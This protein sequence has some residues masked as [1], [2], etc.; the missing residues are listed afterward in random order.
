M[1]TLP[2]SIS[3]VRRTGFEGETIVIELTDGMSRTRMLEVQMQMLD[4]A[5][6]V[7]GVGEMPCEFRLGNTELAGW[8]RDVKH[9]QVTIEYGTF[10]PTSAQVDEALAPFEVDGWKA[11]HRWGDDMGNHHRMVFKPGDGYRMAAVSIRRETYR[12]VFVRFLPP[13]P[14]SVAAAY[15]D[16]RKVGG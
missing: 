12:V 14:G 9:E 16:S 10:E 6:A 1:K 8:T 15:L 2:G 3:I 13:R 5:R 11:S 7:T 4:F